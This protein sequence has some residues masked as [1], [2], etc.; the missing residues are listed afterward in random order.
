DGARER[1]GCAP[2]MGV[3]VRD[4]VVVESVLDLLRIEMMKTV[5]R[6]NL[7]K[8]AFAAGGAAAAWRAGGPWIE[9]AAAALE[10]SHFVHIWFP[11]GLN[12][13]FA[14]AAQTFNGKEFGCADA[15]I[16]AVG[17]GVFTD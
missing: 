11:G 2:A 5:S 7:L 10:P 17:N 4:G 13:L 6:R 16:K 9:R 8:G 1:D 15:N 3:R 14:G 12:A